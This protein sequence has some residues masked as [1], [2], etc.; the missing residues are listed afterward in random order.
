[1]VEL[2]KPTLADIPAMQALVKREVASGVILERSDDELATHIRS[3]VVAKEAD[4]LIGYAA[5]H[6]H[7]ARL[8]EIRSLVVDPLFRGRSIGQRIVQQTLDEARTLGVTEVLSLT[9]V[10]DF[11]RKL[12]FREIDKEQI[13]EQKIWTDCIQCVHFPVCNEV[14]LIY[15][16]ERRS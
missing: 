3:Y 5:L 6:I 2:F 7:S 1:M 15:A 11:F 13:P 10:P 14:S 8:A 9:Y 12:G 4:L 16:I